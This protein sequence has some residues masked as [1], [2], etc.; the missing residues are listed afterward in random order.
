MALVKYMALKTFAKLLGYQMSDSAIPIVQRIVVKI[1]KALL[2]EV[3]RSGKR[4]RLT[5]RMLKKVSTI[6]IYGRHGKFNEVH[7]RVEEGERVNEYIY[8]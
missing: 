7:I 5:G 4:V 6:T 3:P 2:S 1:V 8:K